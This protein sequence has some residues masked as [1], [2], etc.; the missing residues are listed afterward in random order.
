MTDHHTM[1]V[2]RT[3]IDAR[4]SQVIGFALVPQQWWPEYIRIQGPCGPDGVMPLADLL[5]VAKQ[6]R[7][8]VRRDSV[9]LVWLE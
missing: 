4:N 6:V 1:Q 7:L 5:K 9:P 2:Q 8:N 3:V